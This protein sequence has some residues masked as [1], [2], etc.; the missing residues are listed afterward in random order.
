MKLNY[1]F[2]IRRLNNNSNLKAFVTLIIGETD[3]GIAI[4]GFKI[5]NGR[6][7]L[8]VSAPSHKGTITEDGVQVEKYFDD[9]RFI[10]ET[11]LEIGK[12]I[13]DAMLDAYNNDNQSSTSSTP[14]ITNSN[15][16]NTAA[17]NAAAVKAVK[18]SAKRELLWG[19]DDENPF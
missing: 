9:V 12:E 3:D 14:T 5:V 6:N 2:K 16:A 13:K 11:G 17:L 18:K 4:D 7:G 8:F 15:R 1:T 19:D 10:G